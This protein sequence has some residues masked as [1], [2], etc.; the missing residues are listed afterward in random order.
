[1]LLLL[2]LKNS[3][4]FFSFMQNNQD[5]NCV[6]RSVQPQGQYEAASTSVPTWVN[7]A[8]NHPSMV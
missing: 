3:I 1:M 2:L 5:S 8:Y 6:K 7:N 4:E